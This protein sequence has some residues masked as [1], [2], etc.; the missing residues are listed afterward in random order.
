[1]ASRAGKTHID[2]ARPASGGDLGPQNWCS[3]LRQV[4]AFCKPYALVYVKRY[5]LN[6][7]LLL[8]PPWGQGCGL[9]MAW[10]GPLLGPCLLHHF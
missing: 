10:L 4:T 8:G 1:M 9:S 5:Y 2:S 6:W 3:R 7:G